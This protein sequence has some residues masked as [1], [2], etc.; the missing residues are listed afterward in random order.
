MLDALLKGTNDQSIFGDVNPAISK[1]RL[2]AVPDLNEASSIAIAAT[3][4]ICLMNK[5]S[6]YLDKLNDLRD[7]FIKCAGVFLS[8]YANR[9]P[10][11]SSLR[12]RKVRELLKDATV[13]ILSSLC[14]FSYSKDNS[15]MIQLVLNCLEAWKNKD[16]QIIL[17]PLFE[18][19]IKKFNP[20]S[21]NEHAV[22]YIRKVVTTYLKEETPLKDF[23]N[24]SPRIYQLRNGYG[25][26]ILDN[27]KQG[28]SG[29]NFSFHSPWFDDEVVNF[30]ILKYR[31]YT[32]F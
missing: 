9:I 17:I 3:S 26:L 10:D 12:E 4:V 31:G 5:Y 27:I 30:R 6:S 19:Q 7:L 24:G 28:V 32:D 15:T 22:K 16:E 2:M 14:F 1:P 23:T 13:E 21:I 11:N 25:F 29:W 8:L 18:E 20:E